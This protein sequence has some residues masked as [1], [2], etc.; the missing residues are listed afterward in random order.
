M[1][2]HLFLNPFIWLSTLRARLCLMVTMVVLAGCVDNSD[3]PSVDLEH[4]AAA[5]HEPAPDGAL[6]QHHDAHSA[7]TVYKSPTCGCCGKWVDHM[8]ANGF[9][10]AIEHPSDLSAI[11]DQWSLPKDMRS[12]HTA[13]S[14]NG[15]VFEGH[16][17]AKFVQQFLEAPPENAKGLIVPSMPVGSPGMEVGDKFMPY[18]VFLL[19]ADGSTTVFARVNSVEDG[20]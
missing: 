19:L 2:Q 10:S 7:L 17:P 4:P 11:K 6:S 15:Y 12:C 5:T 3:S 1:R 8:S 16:I 14:A 18:T 13:V 20:Q 9:N